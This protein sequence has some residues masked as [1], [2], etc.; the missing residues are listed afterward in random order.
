MPNNIKRSLWPYMTAATLVI[1]GVLTTY[2][3]LGKRNDALHTADIQTNEGSVHGGSTAYNDGMYTATGNYF[4][5]GGA[6]HIGISLTLKNG[7]IVET[8]IE[9]MAERP[10]S[11]NMQQIFADNYRPMV[12]GKHIDE[13]ELTHVSGSS[14]TPKGFNDAVK[15]I[16]NQAVSQS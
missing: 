11:V 7:V 1:A 13:I 3:M 16:K 15:K 4:S 8:E 9:L 2:T 5:P 10:I 14:L 6:E 12:V